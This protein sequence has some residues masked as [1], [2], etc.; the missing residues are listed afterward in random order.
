M[1]FFQSAGNVLFGP[2]KL[3]GQAI[4]GKEGE[5][6]LPIEAANAG[7]DTRLKTL[8]DFSTSEAQKLQD[9]L[10][11][12]KLAQQQLAEGV[13]RRQGDEGVKG[14]RAAANQRGLLYSG[15]RQAD[16]A[17]VR[18]N[19]AAGLANQ[20]N[21]INAKEQAMSED[22]TD[23]AIRQSAL[24]QQLVANQ[25]AR[26]DSLEGQQEKGGIPLMPFNKLSDW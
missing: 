25:R 11:A 4:F 16:E 22:A 1:G 10:P 8:T 24:L 3:V 23:Q 14:V 5:N 9:A 21:Q 13:A 7:L 2:G 12:R 19:A 6:D 17:G 20:T 15:L 26:T 18:A